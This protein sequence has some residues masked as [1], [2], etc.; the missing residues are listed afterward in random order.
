MDIHKPKPWHGFREFLKEYAIIVVGVLTALGAEQAVEAIHTAQKA[1]Q[2]ETLVREEFARNMAFAREKVAISPCTQAKFQ[3]VQRLLLGAPPDR[4]VPAMKPLHVPSRPYSWRQ[5]EAA[6]ASGIADHFPAD[7]R[8]IYQQIYTSGAADGGASWNSITWTED[9]V[10]GRLQVLALAARPLSADARERLAEEAALAQAD[11]HF[12]A[13]SAQ[14][15]L[16]YAAPL[17]L[18]PGK[19]AAVLKTAQDLQPCLDGVAA[20]AATLPLLP[21]PT[22]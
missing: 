6:V 5:W 22:P 12:L 18:P 16:G 17:R 1:A 3:L 20:E 10:V 21:A 14:Q 15:V 9:E 4:P 13:Y 19:A 7:R 11:E 8:L 2:A